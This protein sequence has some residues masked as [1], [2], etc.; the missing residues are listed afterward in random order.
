MKTF[1]KSVKVV[2]TFMAVFLPIAAGSDEE[3]LQG[4]AGMALIGMAIGLSLRK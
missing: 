1:P 3:A 4:F 2:I